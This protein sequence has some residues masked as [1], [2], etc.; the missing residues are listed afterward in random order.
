MKANLLYNKNILW[1]VL[2]LYRNICKQVH[3]IVPSIKPVPGTENVLKHKIPLKRNVKGPKT[4]Y[5][6]IMSFAQWFPFTF[7]PYLSDIGLQVKPVIIF[8]ASYLTDQDDVIYEE[9]SD[10][11]MMRQLPA[12][13]RA[14][15]QVQ[16]EE[17]RIEKVGCILA[18]I[19][20]WGEKIP[21]SMYSLLHTVIL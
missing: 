3:F 4:S 5:I 15:I 13:D 2:S 12:E 20:V 1:P 19:F 16:V 10:R 7:Y 17:F 18:S 11:A 8:T 6:F 21:I 9:K 14:K